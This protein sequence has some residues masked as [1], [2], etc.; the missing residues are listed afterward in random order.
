[1]AN[2]TGLYVIVGV[3]VLMVIW[4]FIDWLIKKLR[5]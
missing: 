2:L 4:E 5:K 3:L 1:M